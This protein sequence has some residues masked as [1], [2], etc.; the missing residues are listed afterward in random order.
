MHQ[1]SPVK[2][3]DSDRFGIIAEGDEVIISNMNIR[4]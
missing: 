1:Q 4:I 2:R 3:R